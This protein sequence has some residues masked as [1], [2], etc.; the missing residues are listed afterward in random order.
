MYVKKETPR[1][2]SSSSRYNDCK[3]LEKRERALLYFSHLETFSIEKHFSKDYISWLNNS[4]ATRYISTLSG[5]IDSKDALKSIREQL[6][7]SHIQF[8][9]IIAKDGNHAEKKVHVGNAKLRKTKAD[10]AI[11]SLMIGDSEARG[12]GIG[13]NVIDAI[14]N[15]ASKQGDISKITAVIDHRNKA[16]I[17]LFEKK[18]YIRRENAS[19]SVD[20]EYIYHINK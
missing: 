7:L 15:L 14:H 17:R 16:S 11:I 19:T 6:R 1:M 2:I 18:G 12:K 3:I 13:N 10:E 8:F 5:N 4:E 20:V 9:A